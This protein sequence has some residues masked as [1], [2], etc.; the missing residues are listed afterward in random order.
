MKSILRISVLGFPQASQVALVV[1]NLAC[2]Q[3]MQEMWVWSLRQR[4]ALEKGIATHHSILALRIPWTEETGGL[5]FTRSHRVRHNRRD[6]GHVHQWLGL[7]IFT[8]VGMGTICG[9]EY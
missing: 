4:D 8:A 5:Q 2:Q 9:Q 1:K 3:G 7:H 6:L